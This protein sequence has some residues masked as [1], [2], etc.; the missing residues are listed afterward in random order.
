M[1]GVISIVPGGLVSHWD[2]YENLYDH[3]VPFA[4]ES[5]RIYGCIF[6][7]SGISLL[8]WSIVFRKKEPFLAQL[9]LLIIL[10]FLLLF[11][12]GSLFPAF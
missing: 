3:Y 10:I 7:T 1:G 5:G 11:L 4:P 8:I 12:V 6:V 2:W 9:G